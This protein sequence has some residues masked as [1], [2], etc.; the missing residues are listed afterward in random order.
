MIRRPKETILV[1]Y[2]DR[3]VREL[4]GGEDFI[5][6]PDGEGRSILYMFSGAEGGVEIQ[7]S[8][9]TVLYEESFEDDYIVL[10]LGATV[11]A[12]QVMISQTQFVFPHS[13]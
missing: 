8:I 10:K 1:V 11:E 9:Q 6:T 7:S 3:E 13:S 2:S 5:I 12:V 4:I